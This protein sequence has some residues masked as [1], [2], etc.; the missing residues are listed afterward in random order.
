MNANRH[1]GSDRQ[2]TIVP[3]SVPS[4]SSLTLPVPSP[5]GTSDNSPPFQRWVRTSE[6]I[7]SRRDGRKEGRNSKALCRIL[8]SLRDSLGFQDCLPSVE[9]LGYSRMSLRDNDRRPGQGNFQKALALAGVFHTMPLRPL[10]NTVASARC[11]KAHGVMQPFQRFAWGREKPLKRLGRLAADIHRA[12]PAVL[13]RPAAALAR[14]DE[15]E[16]APAT[17]LSKL[18]PTY[19]LKNK[20]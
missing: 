5:E 3:G 1:T 9:T 11:K 19:P 14:R 8:S 18:T 2:R 6:G 17:P 16:R 12:E 4:E 13:M 10:I 15:P 20:S 7:K